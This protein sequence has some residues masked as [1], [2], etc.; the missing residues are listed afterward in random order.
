MLT[1]YQT[2]SQSHHGQYKEMTEWW[3]EKKQTTT[4]HNKLYIFCNLHSVSV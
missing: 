3:T 4:C 2:I 1:S